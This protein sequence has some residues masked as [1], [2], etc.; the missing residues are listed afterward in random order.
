MITN[1]KILID[2]HP[3]KPVYAGFGDVLGG[4]LERFLSTKI[5]TNY[6]L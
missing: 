2:S 6:G 1:Q 5:G 4:L 3:F